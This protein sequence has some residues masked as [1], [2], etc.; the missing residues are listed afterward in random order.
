MI[1]RM[2]CTVCLCLTPISMQP[3]TFVYYNV[4]YMLLC[5]FTQGHS[6]TLT[7]FVV[8]HQTAAFSVYCHFGSV[9]RG[10]DMDPAQQALCCFV[11]LSDEL[12]TAHLWHIFE[13]PHLKCSHPVSVS[14]MFHGLPRSKRL[15]WYGHVC[16]MPDSGLPKVMLFGFKP[17]RAV[18][19]DLE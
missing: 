1:L 13:G 10:R 14:N 2:T 17:P 19:K 7:G 5:S 12:P 3:F 16:R 15:S 11:C 9:V 6:L 4:Y 18:K 8:F